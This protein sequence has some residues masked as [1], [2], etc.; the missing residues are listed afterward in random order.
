MMQMLVQDV[1]FAVR[2]LRTNWTFTIAAVAAL[3]LGLGANTAIFSVVD[4]V[5]FR[6]LPYPDSSRMV[7]VWE[8]VHYANASQFPDPS[9]AQAIRHSQPL[10]KTFRRWTEHT[11]TLDILA[12]WRRYEVTLSGQG[13]ARRIVGAAVTPDFFRMFHG[14]TMLGRTILP[15]EDHEGD[16]RVVVLSHGLWQRGFGSDPAIVGRTVMIDSIPHIVI[17]VLEPS[18]QPV[19]PLFPANPDCY[20]T[21]SH[22][23]HGTGRGRFTLFT[24]AGRMRPG[25]S[26]AQAQADI[27]AVEAGLQKENPRYYRGHSIELVPLSEEL[28]HDARPAMLVLLGAVGCVLLICCANVAKL[29]L[30]RATGRQREISIRAVLGAGSARLVRQLLTESLLLA[31]AGGVIG[32]LLA[33]CGV[34]LLVA[35]IPPDTLPRMEQIAVDARVFGFAFLLSL[36]TGLLFGAMPALEAARAAKRGLSESMK[37]GGGV[38]ASGRGR[39]L[40]NALVVVEMSLALV[41]L[42]GAGL[43]IRSFLSLRGVDL[44]IRAEHVLTAGIMLPQTRYANSQQRGEFIEQVVENARHIPGVDAVAVTNSIPVSPASVVGVSGF[45][46]EGV[47]DDAAAYYRTATPDYFRIMGIPL[48]RGRLFTEAD[49]KGG[50]VLVNEAFVRRYWPGLR[51]DS[52]EPLGRRLKVD[53]PWREIVGVVGDIKFAGVRSEPSAEIYL[54]YTENFLPAGLA[55]VVRTSQPPSRIARSLRDAV[56]AVDRDVPLERIA[57]MDD[58]IARE[59]ATPRFHM[60]LIAAFAGLAL[61]LAG[62]G[63]YGVI[64]YSVAQR[65]REIGIRMALG[66]SAAGVLASILREAALVAGVGVLAGVVAAVAA[67]RALATLLFGVKP[68]D[69]LTFAAV[70]LVLLGVALA[71]AWIPAR[72]AMRV[73]PMVA[74]R[75]E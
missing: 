15:S 29:L 16:D 10:D 12:G 36:L 62:V 67:T 13:E 45:A 73:D 9:S 53:Q 49:S 24:A 61:A 18:F 65:R 30:A 2:S 38:G 21:M 41:L 70:A 32:M 64:A 17:G 68:V 5:M 46:I 48:K 7:M 31:V 60:V 74:L 8:T 39:R 58:V 57:T 22:T 44:G 14:Q 69:P 35:A 56:L 59:F 66:A 52:P 47:T 28:A 19:L 34:K 27:A 51:A 6:P 63:I 11:R 37:E 3:A 43:L 72:R 50:T 33:Y 40:R 1:R 55:L 71:A 25:V 23:L 20:L 75:Y 54:P 4:A 42:T 26:I